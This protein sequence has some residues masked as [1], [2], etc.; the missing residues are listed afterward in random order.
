MEAK[1][2]P[3]LVYKMRRW[4][5]RSRSTQGYKAVASNQEPC[6]QVFPFLKLPREIRD[7]VY[8]ELLR[9]T[10]PLIVHLRRAHRFEVGTRPYPAILR[11][12][13]QVHDEAA[14]VLYGENTWFSAAPITPTKLFE[15]ADEIYD[16]ASSTYVVEPSPI[17]MYLPWIQNFVLFADGPPD[18]FK[19]RIVKNGDVTL[20]LRKMGV[21]RDNLKKLLVGVVNQ[22][23]YEEIADNNQDWL[24]RIDEA[25]MNGAFCWYTERTSQVVYWLVFE[26]Q[27]DLNGK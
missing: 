27:E 8:R 18:W 17:N 19:S 12:N 9:D 2:A 7:I 6:Q 1:N 23:L 24:R 22:E 15:W 25:E 4:L 5:S 16:E 3:K 14:A 13:K 11:T 10:Y 21:Q 26:H 20:M